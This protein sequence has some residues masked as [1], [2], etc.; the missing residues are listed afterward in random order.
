MR[1]Q[2]PREYVCRLLAAVAVLVGTIA[3]AAPLAAGTSSTLFSIHLF[4][5]SFS[6]A[7]IPNAGSASTTTRDGSPLAGERA[8]PLRTGSATLDVVTPDLNVSETER[9][10]PSVDPPPEAT[11]LQRTRADIVRGVAIVAML[12]GGG[13]VSVVALRREKSSR[14]RGRGPRSLI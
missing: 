5:S 10:I 7:A 4:A 13:L 11:P 2:Q 3:V 9:L 8:E 12:A 6:G 14:R 1:R